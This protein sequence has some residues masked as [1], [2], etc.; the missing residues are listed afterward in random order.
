MEPEQIRRE[1]EQALS[2]ELAGRGLRFHIESYGCQMNAHDSE[3]I[4]GMLTQIGYLPAEGKDD[5]D[6]ILFNT[7][8]VREHAEK[9]VFGNVGSLK[10][11]KDENPGLVIAVCGCMMQADPRLPKSYTNGNPFVNLVFGTHSLAELPGVAIAGL[12]GGPA[13]ERA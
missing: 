7:C 9:R 8:C 2:Q 12:S 5:A 3:K 10:K 13:A 6:L 11:R 4:A 1:A